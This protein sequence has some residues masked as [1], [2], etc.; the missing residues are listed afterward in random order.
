MRFVLL[1]IL[2]VATF[3][4][5]QQPPPQCAT[6]CN[7]QASDCMKA[8]AASTKDLPKSERGNAMIQCVKTCQDAN[9][10]CKAGC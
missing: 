5:A 9:Q 7:T 10:R 1:A 6:K 8:C 2:V 3:S 4:V